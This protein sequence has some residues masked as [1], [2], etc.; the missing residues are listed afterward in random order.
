MELRESDDR[1]F[2]SRAFDACVATISSS[3]AEGDRE[4]R[5]LVGVAAWIN[6]KGH[7]TAA[8]LGKSLRDLG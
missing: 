7:L 4:A 1:F 2:A 5:E 3:V 8:G 6:F